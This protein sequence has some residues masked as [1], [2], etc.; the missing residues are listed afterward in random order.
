MHPWVNTI[1]ALITTRDL[2]SGL[3]VYFGDIKIRTPVHITKMVVMQ[4]LL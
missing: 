1:F 2:A 4:G 3:C